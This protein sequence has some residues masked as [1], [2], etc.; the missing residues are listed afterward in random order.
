MASRAEKLRDAAKQRRR[1]AILERAYE[2]KFRRE[3]VRAG[4]Q[5]AKDYREGGVNQV[6]VGIETIHVPNLQQLLDSLYQQGVTMSESY[7]REKYGKSFPHALE[8][9]DVMETAINA[10]RAFWFE[11]SFVLATSIAETTKDYLRRITAQAVVDGLDERQTAT[12]IQDA[13]AN[14]SRGRARTIARTE[15]HQAVMKSQNDIVESMELPPYVKE[16]AS[17]SDGRVRK[18]HRAADGQRRF[19]DNSFSVGGDKLMYP[20]ERGGRPENV[21]NCRCVTIE[22]FDD[23]EERG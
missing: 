18:S 19:P 15:S 11:Q 16:W 2:P 8:T 6:Q 20:G 3:L 17:G 4:E 23:V 14:L 7:E 21:I 1:I 10:L 5:A 22:E 12:I 13:S 9:K